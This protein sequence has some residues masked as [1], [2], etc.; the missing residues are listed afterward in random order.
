[1]ELKI[2]HPFWQVMG[3]GALA[4][5]RS[6]SAPV[7]ASHILSHHQTKRLDHSPLKFMQSRNVALALK[8]LAVGEIIGDKLPSAKDR[9]KPVSVVFRMMSGALAGA[10]IYKA[11]GGNPAAG[12]LIG[13]AAAFASTFGSFW[14]RK[15]AVKASNVTDPFV[16]AIEDALVIGSG[17]E[18]SNAA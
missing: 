13:G 2:T 10:S 18:F 6:T 12:A 7:I 4:G 11:T 1:M 17:I 9:I 16:G 3:L 5:M 14:L 8:I 15:D